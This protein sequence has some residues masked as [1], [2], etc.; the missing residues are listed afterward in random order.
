MS[1]LTDVGLICE[2]FECP[3]GFHILMFPAS[4]PVGGGGGLDIT[5]SSL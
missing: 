5:Q 4:A 1:A 2:A 3:L